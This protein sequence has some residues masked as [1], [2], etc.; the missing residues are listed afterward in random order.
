MIICDYSFLLLY[1]RKS[2]VQLVEVAPMTRRQDTLFEEPEAAGPHKKKKSL[3][4]STIYCPS[5]TSLWCLKL[6]I[7][8]YIIHNIY[9]Y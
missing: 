8:I 2:Q 6:H 7:S 5:K 4:I 9:V 1:N 3:I